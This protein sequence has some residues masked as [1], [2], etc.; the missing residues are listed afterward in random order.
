[1]HINH[2]NNEFVFIMHINHL[3][4]GT[5]FCPSAM[6]LLRVDQMHGDA[7]RGQD[8]GGGVVNL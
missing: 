8:G 3:A 2:H 1:M 4:D 6:L 7:L 5:Q